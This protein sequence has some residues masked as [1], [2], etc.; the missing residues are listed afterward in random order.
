M[1]EELFK[2]SQEVLEGKRSFKELLDFPEGKPERREVQNPF[3]RSALIVSADRLEHVRKALSREADVIIFNLED[4]VS[5]TK[6]EFGRIFLRKFLLN[7]P[8][9]GEKEVVV[10]VNPIDSPYFFEDVYQVLPALP[11]AIRISKVRS[12]EDVVTLDRLISSFERSRGVEEGFIR[13]QLSI[14]TPQAI[15]NLKE[16]LSA[17]ERIDAA[18]LGIL[19]L[20]AELGVSQKFQGERLGSY[21]REKF[22]LECRLAG[23]CPIGPAYQDYQDLEGFKREAEFERELGFC[24]KMAISVRQSKIALE[25]FSPSEEEVEEA[26]EIV[27]LY[28]RALKEGKGGITYKGKFIDQ[29]IYKDALNTLRFC[30]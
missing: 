16:I 1:V 15:S 12:P 22:S 19:D 5:D 10:R 23:V 21:L 25:V 27:E 13:I 26:K 11:H 28:E 8:L 3:K 29:P 17:S 30:S 20:F 18:Y 14:E 24:G 4:G 7:T 2:V 6:K 9:L